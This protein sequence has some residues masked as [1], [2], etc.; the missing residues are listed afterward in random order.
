[1][2]RSLRRST[3]GGQGHDI[4]L[5]ATIPATCALRS[6]GNR[7]VLTGR[8]DAGEVIALALGGSASGLSV[9]CNTP[10]AMSLDRVTT[11]FPRRTGRGAVA[12]LPAAANDTTV[13]RADDANDDAAFTIEV[14]L[15]ARDNRSGASAVAHRCAFSGTSGDA[16]C[17]VTG[18][19]DD[20]TAAPPRG[21]TRF[22]LVSLM[23][24]DSDAAVSGAVDLDEISRAG[25]R[26]GH[27]RRAA[28]TDEAGKACGARDRNRIAAG[29]ACG[30]APRARA[31]RE[32]AVVDIGT[33]L[34]ETVLVASRAPD[35]ISGGGILIMANAFKTP[36]IVPRATLALLSA[37]VLVPVVAWATDQNINLTATVPKFC[38]FNAVPTFSGLNNFSVASNAIG[39]S[40][41]PSL[42][43]D[44]IQLES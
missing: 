23:D 32:F 12:A 37:A 41:R 11:L 4:R 3:A 22:A 44:D 33:I 39:S 30:Y 38:K 7:I 29:T 1:M 6:A 35:R 25:R 31:E 42:N 2:L 19:A 14:A 17:A 21:V 40:V 10:Y 20:V 8:T 16:G 26:R 13:A 34:D 9:E 24:G 15:A 43:A 5:Q 28:G 18:A 27:S 36:R